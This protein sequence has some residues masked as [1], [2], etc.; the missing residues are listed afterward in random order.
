[1]IE[2]DAKLAFGPLVYVA[3]ARKKCIYVGMSKVGLGR[4]FTNRNVRARQSKVTRI[5]VH[6]CESVRSAVDL[7]AD[8]TYRLKPLFKNKM[9]EDSECA[10]CHAKIKICRTYRRRRNLC[11]PCKKAEAAA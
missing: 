1:M 10:K 4:P 5:Q 7:E 9:H 11:R 6:L 3:F 2:F 8:L